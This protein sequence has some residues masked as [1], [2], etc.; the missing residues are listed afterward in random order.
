[1]EIAVVGNDEFVLGFKLVGIRKTYPV[2][3]EKLETKINEVLEDKNIGI[4]ILHNDALKKLSL[5]LRKRLPEIV[6]PVVITVGLEEET[7][8]RMKVKKA[9]G[10]D[11]YKTKTSGIG[12]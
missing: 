12:A 5:G 3:D 7:D 9:I 6:K 4:L 11:L 8:L 2:P 10:I 1:M